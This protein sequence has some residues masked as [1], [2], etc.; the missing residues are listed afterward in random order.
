MPKISRLLEF[1]SRIAQTG[2]TEEEYRAENILKRLG[3]GESRTSLLD[4]SVGKL[5]RMHQI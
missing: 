4:P 1:L 3:Y 5:F 2:Q